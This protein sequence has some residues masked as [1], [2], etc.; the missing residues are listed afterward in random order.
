MSRSPMVGNVWF[1]RRSDGSVTVGGCGLLTVYAV[2]TTKPSGVTFASLISGDPFSSSFATTLSGASGQT[3]VHAQ[4][5]HM[6]FR[7]DP[8]NAAWKKLSA[9]VYCWASWPSGRG[10]AS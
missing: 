1:G 7:N 2:P 4:A 10:V 9:I 6:A 3:G 5:S 8:P